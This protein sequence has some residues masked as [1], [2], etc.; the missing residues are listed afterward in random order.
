MNLSR[1]QFF[2]VVVFGAVGCGLMAGLLF[3]FS[4]FVMRALL[5]QAPES[6][7]RTM[8]AVNSLIQ[9]PI[10]FVLF[11][12]TAIAALFL[13][14]TSALHFSQTGS[15]LLFLGS[16]FFLV[17]TF[18]VTLV[19]NVPLN[20]TLAEHSASTAEAA[21]FW[22]SYVEQWL[23]WNHVRTVTS[24]SAAALLTWAAGLVAQAPKT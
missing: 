13:S 16:M 23:K 15:T 10:F 5:Q 11:F 21:Q 9:N 18:G 1:D 17:G 7:I 20:N 24:V 19:F 12:G 3:A 6:G 2:A 14:V 22:Q 8:Q 4:N